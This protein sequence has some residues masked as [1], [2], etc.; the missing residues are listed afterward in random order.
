MA[1]VTLEMKMIP[2][3]FFSSIFSEKI[4][5]DDILC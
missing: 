3:I 2:F 1:F 4:T 5:G